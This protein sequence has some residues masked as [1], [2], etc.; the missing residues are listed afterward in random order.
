M[1]LR[2]V[3][4]I[5]LLLLIGTLSVT[6]SDKKQASSPRPPC[7]TVVITTPEDVQITAEIADTTA[8]Q[9]KGLSGR[10]VL[11][12]KAG[13]LFVFNTTGIYPFWMK[14]TR[15]PLDIIW[16]NDHTIVEIQS[17]EPESTTNIPQHTPTQKAD[18]V[19]E[20]NQGEA[21]KFNLTPGTKLT[22]EKCW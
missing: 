12:P 19:L 7:S 14:D 6:L 3:A 10:D 5:A 8:K 2:F 18:T 9:A 21:N 16:I 15:I 22:W 1:N 13:M 20:L 4:L 11:A 17:L